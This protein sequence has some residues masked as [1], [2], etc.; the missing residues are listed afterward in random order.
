MAKPVPPLSAKEL[1]KQDERGWTPLFYAAEKGAKA[2]V[3][4]MLYCMPATGFYPQ[5]LGFIEVTDKE[6][7]TAVAIAEQNGHKEIAHL[8]RYEAWR[9]ETFG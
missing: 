1:F 7:Q 5:R 4:A 3:E 6:G 8:L 2:E 9:M